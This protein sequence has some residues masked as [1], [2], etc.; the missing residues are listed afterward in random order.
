[1][2]CGN[3][4][5]AR[6]EPYQST[7]FSRYTAGPWA[8]VRICGDVSSSSRR[9][10][11]G[12]A[13][14]GAG[15]TIGKR[16]SHRCFKSTELDFVISTAGVLIEGVLNM[17]IAAFVTVV[18]IVVSF[19]VPTSADDRPSDPFGNHTIE[20]DKDSLEYGIP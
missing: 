3:G 10:S 12:L 14:R 16:V 15:T 11:G 2:H 4:F 1:V 9:R 7:R 6:F 17:H 5:H 13:A 18:A 20:L 19:A 8:W